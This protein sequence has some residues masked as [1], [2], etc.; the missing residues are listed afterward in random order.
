MAPVET[1]SGSSKLIQ[2]FS[3]QLLSHMA[4]IHIGPIILS[5]AILTP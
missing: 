1:E 4:L 2:F 3:I 5:T